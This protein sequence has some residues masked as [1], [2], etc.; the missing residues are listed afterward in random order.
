MSDEELITK[1]IE[2]VGKTAEAQNKTSEILRDQ[3]AAI[4]HIP[5]RKDLF[6][7]NVILALLIL[8]IVSGST[9]ITLAGQRETRNVSQQNRQVVNTFCTTQPELTECTV[10]GSDTSKAAAILANCR[11]YSNL[12]L[13]TKSPVPLPTNAAC[14]ALGFAFTPTTTTAVN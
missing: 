9:L 1:I 4:Q 13:A 6:N 11:I 12:Y 14:A 5:S 2:L 7:A 8:M 10:E 3:T